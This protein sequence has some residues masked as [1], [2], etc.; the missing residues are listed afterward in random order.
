M[1]AAPN[2]D[3]G[4]SVIKILRYKNALSQMTL[5]LL[6]ISAGPYSKP[7]LQYKVADHQISRP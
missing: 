3:I 1:E 5:V 6:K 2:D 4:E 7:Q